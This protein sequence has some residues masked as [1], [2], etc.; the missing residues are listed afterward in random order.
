MLLP[1]FVLVFYPQENGQVEA[2][3]KNL[4]TILKCTI[5]TA[6]YNWYIMLYP[7]LWAY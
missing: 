7:A 5:T 6:H 4:K 3:N 2:V 1:G